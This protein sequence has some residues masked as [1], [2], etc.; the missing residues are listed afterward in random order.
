MNDMFFIG[1]RRW[2]ALLSVLI[3][4]AV[5]LLLVAKAQ[6]ESSAYPIAKIKIA[7]YDP[8]DLLYGHYLLFQYD[9][10][11][12]P[13]QPVE[14]ACYGGECCLCLGADDVDPQ[15]SVMT[16][17]QA[18]D[19][20]CTRQVRGRYYGGD[21]FDT[22]QNRYLVSDTRALEL[23][24]LL[25]ETPDRFRMGI[26]LPPNG[27]VRIEGLYVDDTPLEDYLRLNPPPVNR[28]AD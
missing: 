16:C 11:W 25:R 28:T 22:G 15:V 21:A 6:H 1:W 9:W 17:A 8:R 14:N 7:G 18:K 13:G 19:Q 24:Y 3:A 2:G 12:A 5:P 26:T 10:N 4:L 23:E 20:Q 27:K